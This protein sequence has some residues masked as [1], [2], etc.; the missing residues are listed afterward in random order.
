MNKTEI[1]EIRALPEKYRPMGPWKYFGLTI[2]YSLPIIG[3][4]FCIIHA[5]S[6]S[7]INRRSYARMFFIPYA[8][9]LIFVAIMIVIAIVGTIVGTSTGLFNDLIDKIKNLASGASSEIL[10]LFR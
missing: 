7:N 2:L 3:L 8:I 9:A 1:E 4:I 6:R 5:V 10:M